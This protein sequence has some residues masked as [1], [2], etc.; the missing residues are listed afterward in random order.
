MKKHLIAL[1]AVAAALP[2][3]ANAAAI[4]EF[5]ETYD[6]PDLNQFKGD[7]NDLGLYKYTNVGASIFL[8]QAH[9]IKF[10][11]LGAESDYKDTFTAGSAVWNETSW[12]N[13]PQNFFSDPKYVGTSIF[14]GDL[15]GKLNFTSVEGTPATVGEYGF[16]IF[17]EAN[18][19]GS[20]TLQNG[21]SFYIGYDDWFTIDDNHDDMLIKATLLPAVPEPSTWLMMILGFG[22]IGFGMR[23]RKQAPRIRFNYA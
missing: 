4:I 15:L 11:F 10:E 3:S 6:I 7:L 8:D 1:A 17:L 19:N 13:T 9:A 16:A 5:G 18:A 22:A 21:Q 2:A 20:V 23:Q 14:E 12:H